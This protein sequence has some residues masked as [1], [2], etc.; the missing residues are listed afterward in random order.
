MPSAAPRV[1]IIGLA[2]LPEVRKG[3]NLAALVARAAARET[4]GLQSGD[5]VVLTQKIVSKAEGRLVRLSDVKPSAL[6]RQWAREFRRDPRFVEVVLREAQRI[7]RMD[8]RV[9]IAETRHGFVA[10]N[11]GVDHSNVPARGCVL[12]LPK[13][14]DA[15]ARRFVAAVWRKQKI[16]IAAIV[17]DTFGRPW[18][19]GLVNVAIGAAGL[20]VLDDWRGRRDAYGR[21]L[22]ATVLAVADEL[23]AA[24]GLA[25]AKNKNVPVAIVRGY[26]FRSGRGGAKGL[27][28]P[29]EQD[30]FR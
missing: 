21:E 6:A 18:R 3:A 16:R 27:I 2:T 1:E 20:E 8:E 23:A 11:A 4:G 26:R 15:T 10:A 5:V 17:S 29:A 22:R 12:C 25:M 30:L 14:P 9:L 28:R 13:N 7:V 19:L 24:A